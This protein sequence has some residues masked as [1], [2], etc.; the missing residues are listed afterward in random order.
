VDRGIRLWDKLLLCCSR[1]ALASWWVDKELGTAF[2]KEERLQKERNTKVHSVIPLNLD[3]Y[4]F[5]WEDGK[6]SKLRERMAPSFIGWEQDNTIFEREFA[7]LVKAL[8]IDDGA[9]EKPP[10][11]RL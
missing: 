6:A 2:E 7:K 10:T 8:R 5:E 11:T 4:L 3:N 1:S 9:R